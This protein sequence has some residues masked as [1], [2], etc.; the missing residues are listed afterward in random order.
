[1][2]TSIH[3]SKYIH[4]TQVEATKHTRKLVQV[5]NAYTVWWCNGGFEYYQSNWLLTSR[6]LKSRLVRTCHNAFSSQLSAVRKPN[7]CSLKSNQHICCRRELFKCFVDVDEVTDVDRIEGAQK[8]NQRA[9]VMNALTFYPRGSGEADPS[10]GDECP[11]PVGAEFA[12]V[13]G[14]AGTG[15][16]DDDKDTEVLLAGSIG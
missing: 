2:V 3:T 9:D 15:I 11:D 12:D 13:D 14:V 10:V 5:I 16:A 8:L 4:E 7:I 6:W 1:M